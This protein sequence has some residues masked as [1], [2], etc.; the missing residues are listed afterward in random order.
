VPCSDA[1][2]AATARLP[3]EFAERF[4]A[5]CAAP[6]VLDLLV[7]KASFARAL[8][9]HGV[10]HPASWI[11][12]TDP[13]PDSIPDS[14]FE[15]AFLKPL[16]SQA[17]FAKFGV[18]GFWIRS[19]AEA[20]ARRAELAAAGVAVIL[21]EYVPG[22][23]DRHWFLD[24]LVDRNGEVSGLLVRRRLR[25]FPP[26]FGNSSAMV[27]VAASRAAPAV[28]T[29][30]R[31]LAAI[32]YRGPFSAEFKQDARDDVFR[33]LEVNARMWWYVEFAARSGVNVPHLAWLDALGRPVPAVRSYE[34][35]RRCVYPY[36][37][38]HATRG[39]RG[40]SPGGVL[41]WI[42]SSLTAD[43][44]VFRWSDPRPGLAESAGV[45]AAWLRRRLSRGTA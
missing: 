38:W 41:R 2:A 31:F 37:D 19:R 43:Q 26:D 24:G 18:K 44:P 22:P 36:Y 20:E 40:R 23:A 35:G 13:L 1:W 10:P 27:S 3:A 28:E 6:E 33:I 39:P 11:V 14:V 7:D 32:G 45:A 8:Q 9:D 34:E 12:G 5:S 4:P 16:D 15:A 29:L 17:C 42:G 30:R 25:M 21:Q